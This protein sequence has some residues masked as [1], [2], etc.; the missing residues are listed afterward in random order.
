M[1]PAWG[2]GDISR[3]PTTVVP[4]L[5]DVTLRIF[6]S[7]KSISGQKYKI[8]IFSDPRSTTAQKCDME[9][10]RRKQFI[11]F[12]WCAV[13]SDA[14]K[15]RVVQMHPT[16]DSA[17]FCPASPPCRRFR[18]L[19]TQKP[20]W[21]SDHQSGYSTDYI[22]CTVPVLCCFC[23]Y[24]KMPPKSKNSNASNLD[25]PKRKHKCFLQVKRSKFLT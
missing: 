15:S 23:F 21:A 1:R 11:R 24:L 9:N 6:S 7:L 8:C 2:S 14:M 10:S 5:R 3:G 16:L 25:M 19:V 4:L 13:L 22:Q 12:K 17:S 20:V 18:S